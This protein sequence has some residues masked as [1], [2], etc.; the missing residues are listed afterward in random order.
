M[1]NSSNGMYFGTQGYMQWIP[2]PSVD[3]D[4]S[5]V[6]W[7][8]Q[9]QYL[10]GGARIRRSLSAH[11]EYNLAWNLQARDN[12]RV[13]SDYADGVYGDGLIYFLDPFAIDK[14]VLPQ[15]WATPSLGALD[16]PNLAGQTTLPTLVQTSANAYGHP[17]MSVVYTLAG[18]EIAPEIYVPI[19]QGYRAV[20]GWKGSSTGTATVSI[21][22]MSGSSVMATATSAGIDVTSSTLANSQVSSSDG[23]D[24]V[25]LNLS[26]AGN[27]IISSMFM[28]IIP[29]A[30]AAP[31]GNFISGQGNSG[32]HFAEHP[33]LQNYSSAMDFVGMTARLIEVGAWE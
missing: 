7:Q 14:N 13:V 16:G 19:P 11:K 27:I 1:A 33:K 24:G 29:V 18:T 10:N 32:C 28:Q 26:G 4:M 5:K 23:Y 12:L 21:K 31:T 8:A 3:A 2:A 22:S 9:A 15:Y 25:S 30:Q 17:A 6:G 20:F